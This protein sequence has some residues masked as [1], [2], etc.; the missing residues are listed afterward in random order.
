[1][2]TEPKLT[3][4]VVTPQGLTLWENEIDYVIV[5]RKEKNIAPGSELGIWP[6]HGA[7]LARIDSCFLRYSR[8]GEMHKLGV[9][10]GILE[11]KQNQVT[12]VTFGVNN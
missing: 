7:L 11:V 12:V 8:Q 10:E 4:E 5:R 6:K 1:M 2:E 9:T 3:L